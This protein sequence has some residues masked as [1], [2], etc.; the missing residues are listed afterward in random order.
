MTSV[1]RNR[2]PA[3]N[4]DRVRSAT[5]NEI[6]VALLAMVDDSST[7]VEARLS[8]HID[9]RPGETDL[10]LDFRGIDSVRVAKYSSTE[11]HVDL[12]VQALVA[13][14]TD[15]TLTVPVRISGKT[16]ETFASTLDLLHVD[17]LELD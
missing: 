8:A 2:T 15:A 7:G 14:R 9:N 16:L 1:T 13:R 12:L 4:V 3:A 11:G 6:K 10:D 17:R 5:L